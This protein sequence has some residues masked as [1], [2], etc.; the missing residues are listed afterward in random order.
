MSASIKPNCMNSEKNKLI[1]EH[2]PETHWQ[3]QLLRNIQTTLITSDI[4]NARLKS[5]L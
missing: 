1:T 5:K 2:F 3:Q 4:K